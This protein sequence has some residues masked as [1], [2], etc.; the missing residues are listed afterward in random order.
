MSFVLHRCAAVLLACAPQF[1]LVPAA[2]SQALA[3][4]LPDDPFAAVAA[5][6]AEPPVAGGLEV[7]VHDADGAPAKDAIVVLLASPKKAAPPMRRA[8]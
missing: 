2:R 1:G 6:P 7:V 8:K 5:M 3:T 4:T